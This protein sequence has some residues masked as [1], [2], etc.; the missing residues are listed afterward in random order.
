M[1][2]YRG[3]W[4]GGYAFLYHNTSILFH[5]P[6]KISGKSFLINV[7]IFFF[8]LDFR[9]M[10][11]GEGLEKELEEPHDILPVPRSTISLH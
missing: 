10:I 5:S 8:L 4:R 9:Q 11:W 7:V 3:W 2:F 6:L 1:R